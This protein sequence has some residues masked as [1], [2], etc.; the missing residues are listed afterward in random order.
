MFDAGGVL[1]THR[2]ELRDLVAG[3]LNDPA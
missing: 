3:F 1:W 2:R